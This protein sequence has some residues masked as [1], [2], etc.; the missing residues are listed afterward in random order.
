[1]GTTRI[2]NGTITT[3]NVE[4]TYNTVTSHLSVLSDA[5][6]DGKLTVA[7]RNVLDTIDNHNI[8]LENHVNSIGDNNP[9]LTVAEHEKFN[10]ISRL[11]E[12]VD[13]DTPFVPDNI[14]SLDEGEGTIIPD[15]WFRDTFFK[16][17]AEENWPVNKAPGKVYVSRVPYAIKDDNTNIVITGTDAQTII[18]SVIHDGLADKL[19][20]N[21]GLEYAPST[22]TVEGKDDYIGKQWAFFWNYGNFVRDEYGTKHITAVKDFTP[23]W[24]NS[25]GTTETGADFDVKNNTAAFGP[26]FWFFCKTENYTDPN[27]EKLVYPGTDKPYTQLW[28]ISDS[29][30]DTIDDTSELYNGIVYEGLSSTEAGQSRIAELEAHGITKNDFHIWPSALVWTGEKYVI[31]PY[32]CEAS[33]A[34]GYSTGTTGM[35]SKANAPLWNNMSFSALY[36]SAV[37]GTTPK[38]SANG[39]NLQGFSALMSIIKSAHKS[40]QSLYSGF[41][42]GDVSSVLAAK[43]TNPA[44]PGYIFP[45]S[46]ISHFNIGSTVRLWQTNAGNSTVNYQPSITTQFGRIKAIENRTFQTPV[47]TTD[48]DGTT[49]TT[50]ETVTSLCLIIDPASDTC[51]PVQPFIVCT[52]IADAKAYTDQGVYAC[53]YAQQCLA[54][55]GETFNG[56]VNGTGVIGKYDGAVTSLSNGRH[57]YRV[58]GIEFLAGCWNVG[59]DTVTLQGTGSTEVNIL[60]T[61][62]THLTGGV[63]DVEAN[64]TTYTPATT[65]CVFLRIP[66]HLSKVTSGTLE[67]AITNGWEVIGVTSKGNG[68][69][70]NTQLTPTGVIYPVLLGSSSAQ[71]H[72]DDCDMNTG[73]WN[74][75]LSGG[76]CAAGA[77]A[78]AARLRVLNGLGSAYWY[79]ASRL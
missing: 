64:I 15:N 72:G 58:Q 60:G 23:S 71:G 22:D 4:V 39:A 77:A 10:K 35:V 69:I 67:T 36:S 18:G 63:E 79:F 1:M 42:S 21:A 12:E 70:L 53:C 59:G 3:D 41:T 31:R 61:G 74:E 28:G 75:L 50:L 33:F 45:I 49:T 40:S 32:W 73:N 51:N 25:A 19:M 14:P 54:M 46:S 7:G 34:G 38:N 55:G 13:A 68:W 29:P 56:G 66:S 5:Q 20:D 62:Y 9:H 17:N 2:T 30:W 78:G 57:P 16:E 26:V 52:S 27:G 8:A 37:N 48:E 44:E 11:F 65:E 76:H 47:T 6:I 24:I 43:A